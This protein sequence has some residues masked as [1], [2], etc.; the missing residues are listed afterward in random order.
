MAINTN[1]LPE[2]DTKAEG[3]WEVPVPFES[4]QLPAFPVEAL[5]GWLRR[6]VEGEAVATQTPPDLGAMLAL[7]ALAV[8]CAKKV[9]VVVR[10][11]WIEP[12]NIYIAV[13]LPPGC[14]KS[15]VFSA[16]EEPI[17]AFERERER[18]VKGSIAEAQTAYDI[19]EVRLK[20][21]KKRAA[22]DGTEAL[23]AKQEAA[24]LARELAATDVPAFP[25]LIADDVTPERL[26]TLLKEQ[27]GRMAVLS[28]EGGIFDTMAGRYSKDGSGNFEVFLKG[29]AGDS[30]NV[31]RVGRPPEH[32]PNPALTVGLAVQ[33]SVL[34]GLAGKPGFRGRGL[35]GR[36]AYALPV[37]NLGRR[38]IEPPQLAEQVRD[39]FT[40]SL[41]VL[42][43][44]PF[45]EDEQG[46]AKTEFLK[47]SPEAAQRI[48]A[49]QAWVEPQ[50][51]DHAELGTLTD[52]AGKLVGLVARIAGLLHMAAHWN[53]D[54]PRDIPIASETV[55]AAI[56]IGKYLIP[57]ARAAFALMGADPAVEDAKR[58]LAWIRR[59]G[60]RTFSK[61]DAF[62]GL[63]ARF[64]KPADLDPVLSA[65][66]ERDY[67]RA[68]DPEPR[69]G[70]GRK[71]SPKFGVN[72]LAF[73][74]NSAECADSAE[75]GIASSDG[76]YV[77]P[78]ESSL[79]EGTPQN[80]R[81][82]Q[83]SESEL[84]YE[85]GADPELAPAGPSEEV[86]W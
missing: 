46:K 19:I 47:L 7:A 79:A 11:S 20:S 29:H 14:R 10:S 44:L 33:P 13:A 71:P 60:L 55:E 30:L 77:Q 66:A 5:P 63:R 1:A 23:T 32:V 37:N 28:A 12:V 16:V 25:R 17:R 31:D 58:V 15:S 49:F 70:S 86:L 22:E 42:L 74:F 83:N 52:W 59:K 69:S 41:R 67:I 72:P 73:K 21:A 80:P 26:A 78:S 56:R 3:G 84:P 34:A 35:L 40:R 54:A 57:H 39:D 27:G 62:N 9:A 4:F 85:P 8:A 48:T 61:R 38:M 75:G 68:I 36:F 43:A 82:T 65:L 64:P 53:D 45:S 51:A 76:E 50:L 18:D 2:D 6:F 24:T 81:N